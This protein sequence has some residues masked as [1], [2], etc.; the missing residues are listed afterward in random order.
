MPVAKAPQS[1]GTHEKV[2][3]RAWK[4]PS[5]E[6]SDF[7]CPQC[8]DEGTVQC[9]SCNGSGE[10]MADGSRC[11]HC[12]PRKGSGSVPCPGEEHEEV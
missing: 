12:Y 6:P 5:E 7:R 11:Q 2:G 10:G 8:A 4:M 1:P 9:P 3:F